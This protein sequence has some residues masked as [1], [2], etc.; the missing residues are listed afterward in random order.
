MGIRMNEIMEYLRRCRLGN[1]SRE[2]ESCVMVELDNSPLRIHVWYGKAKKSWLDMHRTRGHV[3]MD[4]Q[5][6]YDVYSG[7][8]AASFRA[9][10]PKVAA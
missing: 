4:A 2:G 5:S 7:L 9:A 8:K 6:V 10:K 1:V 3:A